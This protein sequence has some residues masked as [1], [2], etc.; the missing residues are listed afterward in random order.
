MLVANDD[1]VTSGNFPL[2][3]KYK[4]FTEKAGIFFFVLFFDFI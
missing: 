4:D 3:E 2:P 1:D